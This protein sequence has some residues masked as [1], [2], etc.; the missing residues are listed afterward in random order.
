MFRV[1]IEA[2]AKFWA[3]PFPPFF[4]LH[5]FFCSSFKTILSRELALT[6]SVFSSKHLV[7]FWIIVRTKKKEKNEDA[8]EVISGSQR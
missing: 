1:V 5:V 2:K 8:N 4:S 3:S 6:K 7:R